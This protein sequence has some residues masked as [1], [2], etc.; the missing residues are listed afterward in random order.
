MKHIQLAALLAVAGC[1]HTHHAKP[2]APAVKDP[3]R[4]EYGRFVVIENRE[5]FLDDTIVLVPSERKREEYLNLLKASVPDL[6][7]GAYGMELG[8]QS[9]SHRVKTIDGHIAEKHESWREMC[10]TTPKEPLVETACSNPEPDYT[11]DKK[12]WEAE[13][14]GRDALILRDIARKSR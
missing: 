5:A 7:G 3:N 10:A 1:S 14:R 9:S 12:I 8:L 11:E 13:L 2:K 6:F 4:H